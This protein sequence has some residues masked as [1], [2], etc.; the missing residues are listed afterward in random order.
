MMTKYKLAITTTAGGAGSATTPEPC[1]GEVCA[2]Y[3]DL[4]SLDGTTT[5]IVI[6]ANDGDGALPIITLTNVTTGWYNPVISSTHYTGSG[7]PKT[8][9]EVPAVGY[10]TATIAQGG[11]SKSGSL[12]LFIDE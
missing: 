2:I 8:D 4:G 10:I 1:A 6:A 5:D 7:T 11:A 3:V 9:G 12:Y